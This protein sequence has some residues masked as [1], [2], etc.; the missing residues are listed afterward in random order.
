M[1]QIPLN[2]GG[3]VITDPDLVKTVVKLVVPNLSLI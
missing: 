3:P 1:I 2:P